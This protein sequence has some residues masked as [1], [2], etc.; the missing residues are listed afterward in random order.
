MCACVRLKPVLLGIHSLLFLRNL[1]Q[2]TYSELKKLVGTE[3]RGTFC[4]AQKWAQWAKKSG[5]FWKKNS[6]FF[7]VKMKHCHLYITANPISVKS[8]FS[9]FV[10]KCTWSIRLKDYLF[11]V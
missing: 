3:F 11:K 7:S 9:S 1:A 8:C 6:L 2:Y 10:S 4:F 5:F